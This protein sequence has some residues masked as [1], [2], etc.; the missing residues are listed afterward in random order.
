MSYE[1]VIFKNTDSIEIFKIIFTTRKI[2]LS[3]TKISYKY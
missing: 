1:P 2:K 3:I